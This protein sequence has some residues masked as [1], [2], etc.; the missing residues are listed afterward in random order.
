[1]PTVR[2]SHARPSSSLGHL[3]QHRALISSP[4]ADFPTR[5]GAPPPPKGPSSRPHREDDPLAQRSRRQTGGRSLLGEDL[6]SSTGHRPLGGVG[7]M[8]YPALAPAEAPQRRR[9]P[10]ASPRQL[11]ELAP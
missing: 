6:P 8:S 4:A 11:V 10:Q 9:E 3:A 5:K 1:M 7:T 2:A